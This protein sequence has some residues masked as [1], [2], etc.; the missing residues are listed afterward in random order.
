M[1]LKNKVVRLLSRITAFLTYAPPSPT[2]SLLTVVQ[3]EVLRQEQDGHD[4]EPNF[5]QGIHQHSQISQPR[6]Q[7]RHGRLKRL[8]LAMT[9]IPHSPVP[10]D[11]SPPVAA[12]TTFR[13]HLRDLFTRPPHHAMPLVVD[14]SFAKGKE[15]NIAADAPGPQYTRAATTSSGAGRHRGTWRRPVVLLLLEKSKQYMFYR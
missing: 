3:A 10:S 9:R 1:K 15:R 12:T 2:L 4:T 14:V 13:T 5:F 6:P 8:G 11:I 7:Q